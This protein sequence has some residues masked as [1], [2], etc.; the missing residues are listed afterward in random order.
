MQ[1]L[2]ITEV[3]ALKRDN[4]FRRGRLHRQVPL[5]D[6]VTRTAGEGLQIS[7]VSEKSRSQCQLTL[8]WTLLV[9]QPATQSVM[10]H[11]N[12][13]SDRFLSFARFREIPL[14]RSQ[15]LIRAHYTFFWQLTPPPATCPEVY[16]VPDPRFRP[17][18]Q[19]RVQWRLVCEIFPLSTFPIFIDRI[20][21]DR[22][23]Q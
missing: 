6:R 9:G 16:I 10:I 19:S 8:L 20:E 21:R 22:Q 2:L 7:C 15:Q 17:N 3:P 11:A 12:P 18:H 23:E 4:H 13:G 1:S 14:Q 5:P